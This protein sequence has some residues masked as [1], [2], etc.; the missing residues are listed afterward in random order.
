MKR[1]RKAEAETA[2]LRKAQ[3]LIASVDPVPA[4]SERTQ[5]IRRALD[6]R[7]QP[8]AARLPALGLVAL[9]VVFATSAFAAVRSYVER[10]TVQVSTS[11]TAAPQ[12]VCR[13]L[14]RPQRLGAEGPALSVPVRAQPLAIDEAPSS[15]APT[16]VEPAKLVPVRAVAHARSADGARA[17]RRTHPPRPLVAQEAAT[18]APTKSDSELVHRAVKA[19]RRDHDPALAARLLEQ[20]RA[21][22]PDGPLAEE[23][24]SLGVEAATMLGDPR[25]AVLAREYLARYPNGRYLDVVRRALR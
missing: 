19:L 16:A 11:P 12:A 7:R 6:Q 17:P 1:L 23:T 21:R 25:S 24:L 8:S 13:A 22:N 18:A 2:L 15:E 4:S 10:A 3:A 14:R 5:R 9:G 20:Q